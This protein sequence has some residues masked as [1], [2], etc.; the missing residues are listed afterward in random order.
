MIF[1]S[2]KGI[3]KALGTAGSDA[4]DAFLAGI[5]GLGKGAAEAIDFLTG[6]LLDKLSSMTNSLGMGFNE[7]WE[8]LDFAF[9][10][11]TLEFAFDEAIEGIKGFLGISSPSKVMMDIGSNM[12]TSIVDTIVTGGTGLAEAATS[13]IKAFLA[14]WTTI[15]SLLME[16][17]QPALD[18][19][20]DSIKNLFMGD[21]A[22][23]AGD[24]QTAA[25]TSPAAAAA[26]PG[27]AEATAGADR[28]QVINISLNL[29]GKEIDKKVVNLLGGVVKEPSWGVYEWL[30]KRRY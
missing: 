11:E 9:L 14:P 16:I 23:V 8:E 18:M 26:T 12:I 5:G 7:A 21:T 29:D 30:I 19:V 3:K 25:V 6:G 2:G 27:T 15:G 1:E 28:P 22:Q 10:G 13:L 17:I 24:L 4:T 20:P